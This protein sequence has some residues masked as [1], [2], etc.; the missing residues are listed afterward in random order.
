[1][2]RRISLAPI[3][4]IAMVT[5]AWRPAGAQTIS[6]MWEFTPKQGAGAGFEAALKAHTEFRKAQGDPWTW[7][8][9]QEV[10]G[11]NVGKYY[12]ASWNHT[13]SDLDTYDAW[14]GGA[15]AE[16]H[17][18][19]TVAPML[20]SYTNSI[21]RDGDISRFPDDPDYEPTLINVTVFYLIPGKQQAF[22]EAIQKFDEA[23]KGA[24]LP[25]YYSS[26]YMVTG[27]SGPAYSLAGLG[28][29][30]ADFAEGDPSMEQVMME[31]Y[32]EEEMMRIFTSFGES[33]HHWDSFIV[34]Y[35]PDLSLLQGM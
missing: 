25:F 27:N 12:V 15:L 7:Q 4:V 29:S 35:R 32:G 17:F 13:W 26:D 6:E 30:W 33:I 9:Y 18:L 5:V 23:I 3:L 22:T 20:E 31:T 14:A 10:V 16:A 24:D 8:V 2:T 28:T 21:S 11:P 34:R 1:M 19:A